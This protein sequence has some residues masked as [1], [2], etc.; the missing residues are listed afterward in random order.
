MASLDRSPHTHQINLWIALTQFEPTFTA[1]LGE[2]GYECDVIEDQ[3]YI[4]DADG[5]QIIHPDVILTNINTDHSLVIDC[6]S[7][8]LDREQLIRYL[9]LNDHEEQLVVQDVIDGISAGE[10]STEVT[11]SSF[12]DLTDQ[13]VPTDIAVVHFDQDPY[14]GLAIWNPEPQEFSHPPTA[15]LF[16]INVE[17]GE[18]LP[19]GYYP[20]DIYEADKEAMVSSILNSI[21]SLAMKQGE[22]SFEEILDQAH[23]YWDKIGSD[24]QA[25]LLER[26]ERIHAELLDAGLD[27]Y[28]EKIA[29][30]SGQEWGQISATMQAIQART[31]YYV[32]RALD[33]LPQSRLDSDAWQSST[34][35]EDDEENPV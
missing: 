20:F 26:T 4:T 30:T 8:S 19:T 33:R 13:G 15:D 17:P 34:G 23:P 28:V 3:F 2:L 32:D 27:E 12:D 24:K 14:S 21:I 25:E 16:P 1:T 29:G 31:D 22:Y 35:S 9:A 6:K 10:I 18:P 11:L 5:A 7:S